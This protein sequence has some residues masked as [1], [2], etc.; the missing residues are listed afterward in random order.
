MGSLP[1]SI[2]EALIVSLLKPGKT[3]TSVDTYRPLSLINCDAKILAKVLANRLSL[4]MDKLKCPDQAGFVPGRA[5]THNLR[6]LFS[7]KHEIDP[8][9]KAVAVFLD[10]TKAFDS[11]EWEFLAAILKHMGFPPGN[12]NWI[13]LLYRKPSAKLLINRVLTDAFEITRG[14]RQGCPLS[15]FLFALA[16]EPLAATF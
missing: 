1:H 14:T 12:T 9:D 15:P 10:A 13:R 2:R 8:E 5:T 16:I 3:P 4:L 7:I 6:T 11:L